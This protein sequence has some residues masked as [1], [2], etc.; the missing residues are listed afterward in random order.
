[1]RLISFFLNCKKEIMSNR[2]NTSEDKMTF[3]SETF[4]HQ[5]DIFL[6]KEIV[7]LECCKLKIVF[8]Q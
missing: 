6:V 5:K 3:F 8:I 2:S 4:I 7:S 1:M